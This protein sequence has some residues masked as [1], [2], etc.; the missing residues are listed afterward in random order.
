MDIKEVKKNLNEEVNYKSDKLG[1]DGAY[2][3][4]GCIF[5]KNNSGFY[6]QVELMDKKSNSIIIAQLCEIEGKV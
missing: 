3:L 2:I 6:Y 1:I 5:R 4:T